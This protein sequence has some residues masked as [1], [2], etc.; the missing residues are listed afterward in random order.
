MLN[1]L[2]TTIEEDINSLI[3]K[4]PYISVLCDESTDISHTARMAINVRLIYPETGAVKSV[5]INDI[6]YEDGTGEGLFG[7]IIKVLESRTINTGKE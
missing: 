6:E 2:Y 3:A 5:L 1:A 4:Y 7:E